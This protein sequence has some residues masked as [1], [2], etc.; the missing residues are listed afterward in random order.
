LFDPNPPL[1]GLCGQAGRSLR[2]LLL[3][4]ACVVALSGC[5]VRG[6]KIPYNAPDFSAPDRTGLV[7]GAYDVPLGPLDV[8]KVNVFRVPDL[9]GEFQ[10]DNEGMVNLPLLGRLDVQDQ[11]AQQFA[12]EVERRYEARYLNNPSVNVRLTET[13]NDKVVV[14][15]GVNS[16][17][18]YPLRGKST[19]LA[20]VAQAR[21]INNDTG[22]P[23]R[24]AIFRKRDGKTIAAAFD[25][26]AIRHGDMADPL[27]YPGDTIVVDS[28]Q[29]KQL[30]Q[31]LLQ[32]LPVFAVFRSL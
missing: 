24:I 20:V 14:E 19:L 22:N 28:S 7:A 3:I 16:P 29:L 5:A 17:G 18:V 11:N 15:G 32:S 31:Q 23:K 25:L 10:V 9:S 21:G 1:R 8:I 30:Y 4:A 6:G 27:V 12:H 2:D 13:N 26:V